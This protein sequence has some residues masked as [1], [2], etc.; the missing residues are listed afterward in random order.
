MVPG[1]STRERIVETAGR[2]FAERGRQATT[3]RD[4]V[5]EA[6]VN[7]AAINYHFR[8]KDNLY[9]EVLEHGVRAAFK[10][11]P[12]D[13]GVGPEANPDQRLRGVIEAC[14]GRGLSAD[15]NSWHGRLMVREMEDPSPDFLRLVDSIITEMMPLLEDI[16]SALNP[17][18]NEEQRWLCCHSLMSLCHG[19]CKGDVFMARTRPEWNQLSEPQRLQALTLHL[20]Q[21]CLVAIGG[22]S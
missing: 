10:R 20:H 13:G 7:Q 11:F 4:I 2:L 19:L 9:F 21:F 17:N 14:L 12:A 18:L 3:V 15:R 1:I 8:D 6:G 16:V 5:R 22:M